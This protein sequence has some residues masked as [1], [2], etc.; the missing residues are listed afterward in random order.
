VA[1]PFA[2][3]DG[4]VLASGDVFALKMLTRVG[5]NPDGSKCSGPGGSHSN[6]VGLRLYYDSTD[7]PSRFTPGLNA[8]P[9]RDYY[10]HTAGTSSYF[11]I[12]APTG[13][14]AKF[15]T[16]PAINFAG[17]NTWKQIGVWSIAQP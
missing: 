1:V 15:V 9:A 17:G 13:T 4:T 12:T 10:L 14:T 6:A 16:S 5:T 7:R 3:P 2:V 11:D 8:D